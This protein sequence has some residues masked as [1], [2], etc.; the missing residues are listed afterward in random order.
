MQ[1]SAAP[2]PR[3]PPGLPQPIRPTRIT[4]LPPAC[5]L[6]AKAR[7]VAKAAPITV[8]VDLFKNSRRFD[9]LLW[10]E[11]RS[12]SMIGSPWNEDGGFHVSPRV[13]GQGLKPSECF[14]YLSRF[15][16]IWLMNS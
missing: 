8:A 15:L 13:G 12:A 3:P 10:L 7:S 11:V 2:R 4:S 1:L 9:V 14:C 16:R 6:S 5:T